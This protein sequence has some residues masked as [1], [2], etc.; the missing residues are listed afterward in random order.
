MHKEVTPPA[1]G[2]PKAGEGKTDPVVPPAVTPPVEPP[3]SE[4]VDESKKAET[5]T[6][7]PPEPKTVVP[8]KYDLKLPEGSTL[9]AGHIEKVATFAKESGLSNVQ[10]QA[11]L[12]RESQAVTTYV[13]SQKEQLKQKAEDWIED[14]RNDKEIGGEAFAQNVELSKRVLQRFGSEAF[15]KT[16]TETGLG[17]H[18]EMVRVFTRIGKAMAEDKLVQPG[19]QSGGRQSTESIFYGNSEKE[20]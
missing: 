12:E 3:K 7:T 13:D 15:G 16:L 17:N 1:E 11:I 4:A 5:E 2:T 19:S 18:P 6:K 9:D 20:N 8:E 14:G 10:A